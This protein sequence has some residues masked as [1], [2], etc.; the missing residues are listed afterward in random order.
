MSSF[1]AND[2]GGFF[3]PIGLGFDADLNSLLLLEW[4]RLDRL[5]DAVFT[6]GFDGQGPS[7]TPWR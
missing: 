7:F 2:A 5:E 3:D 6:D 1:P 4:Q